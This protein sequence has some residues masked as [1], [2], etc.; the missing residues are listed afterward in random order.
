MRVEGQL[1]FISSDA[2]LHAA[3]QGLGLAY[4]TEV[5][6]S[7]TCRAASLSECWRTG[8][9]RSP[10]ITSTIPAAGSRRRRFRCSSMPFAIEGNSDA[11]HF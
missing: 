10:D 8:A 2:L 11:E 3:L 4:L 7:P 6:F 9:P 1:V 5:R